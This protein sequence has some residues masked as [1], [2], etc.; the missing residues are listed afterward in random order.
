[1]AGETVACGS[2]SGVAHHHYGEQVKVVEEHVCRCG[3][4]HSSNMD[5][6]VVTLNWELISKIFERVFQENSPLDI[7]LPTL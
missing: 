1:M 3:H 6:Q 4:Q 5:W 2:S 7:C